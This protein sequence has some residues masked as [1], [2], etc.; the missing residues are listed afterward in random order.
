MLP[1]ITKMSTSTRLA[2]RLQHQPTKLKFSLETIILDQL[3]GGKC[4][5][6]LH[7]G[8]MKPPNVNTNNIDKLPVVKVATIVRQTDATKRNMDTDD[9]CT[10][11]NRIKWRKNL[12]NTTISYMLQLL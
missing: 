12:W 9:Q 2:L 1:E 6:T 3:G 10:A 7:F 11:N 8:M 4:Q 5:K